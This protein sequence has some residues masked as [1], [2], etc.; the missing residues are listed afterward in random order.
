VFY[1]YLIVALR[2]LRNQPGLTAIKVLSLSLGIICSILVLMH[3]QFANSF[4]KHFDN[5][6]NIYRVVA[7]FTTD[8][9]IDS[10]LIPEGMFPPLLNDYAQIEKGAK[11]VPGNGL[12]ARGDISST[13]DY[14]WVDP[15]ILE[16]FSFDFI[17]GDRGTALAEPNTVVLSQR[18]AFKYF[19]TQDPMGQILTLVNRGDLRVT[20][21]IRDLPANTHTS[22]NVEIMIGSNTGRQFFGDAFMNGQ[23]WMG[24]GNTRAYVVISTPQ[25]AESIRND[26]A[27]FITRNAPEVQLRAARQF[28]LGLDLEP[29]ADIYLSPRTGV[30]SADNTKVIILTGLVIFAVLIL[31]S[32]IINFANLSLSQMQQRGKELGVRKTLGATRMNLLSQ[33]MVESLLLTL[34]ALIVALPVIYLAVGPYTAL[35][36]T[37]FSF[38]SMFASSQVLVIILFVLLT[39]ILSGLVPA[40][41]MSQY[42]PAAAISGN[43]DGG[44]SSRLLRSGLTV[45]QFSFAVILML[46]AIAITAQV[47]HL[48]EVDI[49]FN[50]SNLLILDTQYDQRNPEQFNYDAL[51]NDLRQ[52]PGIVTVSR[53]ESPPPDNG[54]YNPWRRAGWPEDEFRTIS[55]LGIDEHYIDAMQLQLLAG[56]NFSR[57][58]IS[59]Y[60]PVG[61]PDPELTYGVII[62]PAA[63]RNFGFS[64]NEAALN[65]VLAIGNLRFRVIGVVNE[66]RLSGGMEDVLRSTSLL[67]TGLYPMRTLLVRVDP[68]QRESALQ[69][70]DS[71]WAT[72]R[73]DIPINREFYEQTFNQLI[74]E[75][76]NGIN[77][78]AQFA[79]LVTI[80]IA[81]LGLYAL[82]FYSTQR[83]TKEIGV[84]KVLGASV[85]SIVS[86]LSIDFIK[87]VIVAC[88]IA[89]VLAYFVNNFYFSQ[90]SAQAS[91]SPLVYLLIIAGTVLLALATVAAQCVRAANADPVKSLRSE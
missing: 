18:A 57:E 10:N 11:V 69:H 12:I 83:R 82:A 44:K 47:R 62:T 17:Q 39:G 23:A 14:T 64:S 73:P 91:L 86:L 32:S 59:D 49:G 16:I 5:W 38:G 3:V 8:Q 65:E 21:V 67:R 41:K 22:M 26:F 79:A 66:F 53:T 51:V 46:L 7:S 30:S 75:E 90:F 13:N 72:H 54:G 70:I 2:N 4:D 24:F 84:R 52:H 36:A 77:R 50:R 19:G 78:A 80:V 35:T 27:D 31:L 63:V 71:V 48:N 68:A 85:S 76:T 45:V 42:S 74:Y 43:R 25:A 89:S 1:N 33:F 56:R 20:G 55:H 87:P 29:L 34:V 88:V 40:L 6:Q 9:R 61:Q 15:E 58:F 60:M 81:A 28:D 37:D